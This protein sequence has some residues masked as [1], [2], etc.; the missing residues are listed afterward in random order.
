MQF[1][2]GYGQLKT[3]THL[4]FSSYTPVG[5]RQ[6]GGTDSQQDLLPNSQS[7]TSILEECTRE[8]ILQTGD[9]RKGRGFASSSQAYQDRV[10]SSWSPIFD[11]Y[12]PSLLSNISRTISRH[13]QSPRPAFCTL[14]AP[15]RALAPCA[16]NRYRKMWG[17]VVEERWMGRMGVGCLVPGRG[18]LHLPCLGS[19][20]G[21][22]I[23]RRVHFNL[24]RTRREQLPLRQDMI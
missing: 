12:V 14:K 16:K 6:T 7:M 24:T 23:T 9:R 5:A 4:R 20:V 1:K 19:W 21:I 22:S 10:Y 11:I 3:T 2:A 8:R 18:G 15:L 17:W 13:V